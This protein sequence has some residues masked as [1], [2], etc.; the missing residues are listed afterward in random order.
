MEAH[1]HSPTKQECETSNNERFVLKG[2]VGLDSFDHR[3]LCIDGNIRRPPIGK[4]MSVASLKMP[5]SK[6]RFGAARIGKGLATTQ[7]VRGMTDIK[8]PA[9]RRTMS[10]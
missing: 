9:R 6:R 10:A 8:K 3:N 4:D 2:N 5:G 7:I 1:D